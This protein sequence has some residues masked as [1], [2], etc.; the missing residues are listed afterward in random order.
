MP[1]NQ[2]TQLPARLFRKAAAAY[3]KT[4]LERDFGRL[5]RQA[6]LPSTADARS[7]GPRVGI[8]TF[9][10]GGWHFVIEALLG[11]A[12]AQRGA[13][14]E[15]LVCDVPDLPICDE[16]T[17][18][19]REIDRC[20]GCLDDKR[21]LLEVCGIPW[22]GVSSLVSPTTLASARA[23]V[24]ALD[25]ADLE[26]YV[27]RGWP[28]GQWLH[29]SACHFLRCD[30]RGDSPDKVQVRRRLLT[31]AIV[32][33]EA[34]ERWLDEVRPEIVIAESGAHF[35]WRIAL[36]LARARGISVVC[37]EMGKGGWDSHLYAR[38]A[39]CMAPN[40]SDA[41][42]R[43]RDQA[44]SASEDTEVDDFLQALPEKT[45]LQPTPLES[46]TPADLRSR[47]GVPSGKKLAVAFTNVTWDLAT[48]GRDVAFTGV[49]DWVRETIRAVALRPD[50]HL[51]VR[52]HPAEASVATRERILD[53]VEQEWPDGL[54]GLTL[55]APEQAVPARDLC[56]MSDLVL[57]YNSTAGL[58]A[59]ILGHAV[60]VCGDPH[61][62]GRGFTIDMATRADYVTALDAWAAGRRCP[63]PPL[64]AQLARR[65]FHLF[66]LR[67]HVTMGW[68][69]SPLEPP[70][71]L[72]IRSMDELRRGHNQ[73]L[74]L[75]CAAILEGRQMLLP[76]APAI[77]V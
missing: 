21:A 19:S 16:R 55:V 30:A 36:E 26:A 20:A 37:R 46:R 72:I 1:V 67:Y 48:A 77:E 11:H 44:L 6:Q 59:A 68:T 25:A 40:L 70:Y 52:A 38:N 13:R 49:F 66:F 29:V 10:S 4:L 62:R 31:S 14:P 74:D 63:P 69:T 45:Y 47:L 56:A 64:A 9:G 42:S 73:A 34:V 22:R 60:M 53:Q 61:Y 27:E 15:L 23:T 54:P 2:R 28:I 43:A 12:L 32:V 76:R 71:R 57:A 7:A 33:V 18:H 75:V 41:W 24:A 35:M 50:A 8:A 17:I 58:E 3:H 65:Y 5:M 51:I 39:D